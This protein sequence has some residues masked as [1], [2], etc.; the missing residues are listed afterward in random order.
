VTEGRDERWI[1]RGNEKSG[2]VCGRGEER[3]GQER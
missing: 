2:Y 3:I 1:R